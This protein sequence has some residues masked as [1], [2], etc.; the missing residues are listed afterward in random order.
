MGGRASAAGSCAFKVRT[1]SVAPKANRLK[2]S[3]DWGVKMEAVALGRAE[4]M[5]PMT[6]SRG[7]LYRTAS[8]DPPAAGTPETVSRLGPEES[9]GSGS[10]VKKPRQISTT[11]LLVGLAIIIV[12]IVI[13]AAISVEYLHRSQPSSSSSSSSITLLPVG[14]VSSSLAYTQCAD[15]TFIAKTPGNL[16][17][18]Y[19]S[20][21]TITVYV[22][23][24]TDFYYLAK[25][26]SV[27]GYLYATA[28]VWNGTIDYFIPA[29]SWNLVFLNTNQY[30]TS[31][32]GTTSPV[33]FTPS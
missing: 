13:V 10:R 5:G 26:L 14:W 21:D 30:G 18:S 9:T 29:G 20:V 2:G 28:Q 25:T 8:P 15:V 4:F 19:I 24:N 23:N 6:R 32:V 16:T 11:V 27:S 33:V 1:S 12:I 7:A 31:G 3:R 17:G 22:M